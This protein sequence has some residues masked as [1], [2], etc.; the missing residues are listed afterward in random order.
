MADSFVLTNFI[1]FY[2]VNTL[3]SLQWLFELLPETK[4]GKIKQQVSQ[5]LRCDCRGMNQFS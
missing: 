5:L 3:E 2:V 1:D 4:Q